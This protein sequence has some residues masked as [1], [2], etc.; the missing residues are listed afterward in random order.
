M[1][2]ARILTA[3]SL[4]FL[5]PFFLLVIAATPLCSVSTRRRRASSSTASNG[6]PA[7]AR[8]FVTDDVGDRHDSAGVYRFVNDAVAAPVCTRER[9]LSYFVLYGDVGCIFCAACVG[10]FCRPFRFSPP[11]SVKTKSA[12]ACHRRR[13][14]VRFVCIF[15]A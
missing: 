15:I 10:A 14:F 7:C 13:P 12:P 5:P 4:A 11:C 1:A 2:L 3:C 6:A 9:A 8:T